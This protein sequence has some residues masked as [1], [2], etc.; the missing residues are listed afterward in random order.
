MSG[1]EILAAFNLILQ[2]FSPAI[3][4]LLGVGIAASVLVWVIRRIS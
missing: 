1:G 2:A 3:S 4:V